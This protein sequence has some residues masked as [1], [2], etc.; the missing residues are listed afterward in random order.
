MIKQ[1]YN[2]C[3]PKT[4]IKKM[5]NT[6]KMREAIIRAPPHVFSYSISPKNLARLDTR[7]IQHW[8]LILKR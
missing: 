8:S 4:H 7:K 5:M 3:K 1:A 6:P 2:I